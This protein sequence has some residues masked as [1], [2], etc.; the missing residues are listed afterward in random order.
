MSVDYPL[1]DPTGSHD[2]ADIFV[3]DI[4]VPFLKSSSR[5][6]VVEIAWPRAFNMK[7]KVLGCNR[8]RHKYVSR[9]D[10][11]SIDVFLTAVYKAQT[12]GPRPPDIRQE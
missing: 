12:S 7:V 3:G 1:L 6:Q 9:W 11:K 2:H 10:L 5:Y 4:L 8:T